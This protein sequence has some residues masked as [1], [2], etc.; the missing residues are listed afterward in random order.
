MAAIKPSQPAREIDMANS[1]ITGSKLT[2]TGKMVAT[3]KP[4]DAGASATP[5]K[6]VTLK[7]F[8]QRVLSVVTFGNKDLE[9]VV[10]GVVAAIVLYASIK[11]FFA[12]IVWYAE[13]TGRM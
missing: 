10:G 9:P 11:P 1:I 4:Q 8:G 7:G 13:L 3:T 12:S 5:R 2:K 6:R